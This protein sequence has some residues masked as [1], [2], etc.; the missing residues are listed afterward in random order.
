[1][2]TSLSDMELASPVASH[3][4]GTGLTGSME[5]SS[6][7]EEIMEEQHVVAVAQPFG[8][9][10]HSRFGGGGRGTRRSGRM[11]GSKKCVPPSPRRQHDKDGQDAAYHP[12]P[13]PTHTLLSLAPTHRSFATHF[14]LQSG[15]EQA[16]GVSMHDIHTH[17][18]ETEMRNRQYMPDVK[19]IKVRRPFLPHLRSTSRV[20]AF[21]RSCVPA[22]LRSRVPSLS[23]PL[24][25]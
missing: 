14:H 13:P 19:Y 21:L 6:L 15:A 23:R 9:K 11:R 5:A 7:R 3:S 1:V 22:F 12:P 25:P 24:G 4:A 2:Q 16:L 20:P 10:V 8:I 17:M 18:R